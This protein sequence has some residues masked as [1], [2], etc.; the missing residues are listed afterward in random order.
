MFLGLRERQIAARVDQFGQQ[1]VREL[2]D[3]FDVTEVTIRRDLRKLEQA[4]LLKRTHGGA[5]SLTNG[6][7]I[8]WPVLLARVNEAPDDTSSDALILPPIP[9]RVAYTLREGA[10]RNR[11]PI[12]AESVPQDDA[13]YVGHDNLAAGYDL[14][15]WAGGALARRLGAKAPV[16]AL[17]I[18]HHALPNTRERSQGFADGLNASISG[19]H[20]VVRTVDGHGMYDEAYRA[21]SDALRLHPETNLVFGI[22]DDS[23][24]AAIQALQDL[25]REPGDIVVVSIGAEG[26]TALDVLNRDSFLQAVIALFPEVVGRLTIDTIVR[27]W[28]GE[29]VS[30]AVVMPHRLITP[31]SIGEFYARVGRDWDLKSDCADE[32][33]APYGHAPA[34]APPD[35]TISFAILYRTHEWYQNVNQAMRHRCSELGISLRNADWKDDFHDEIRELQRLIGKLAASYIDDGDSVMLDSGVTTEYMCS[36]LAVPQNLSVVTNSLSIFNRLRGLTSIELT[37]TG[38]RYNKSIDSLVGRGAQ[39]TLGD[40]RVNK[41]FIVARGLSLEFGVSAVREAEAEIHR[42]MCHA[43]RELVVLAD[44]TLLDTDAKF[45]SFHLDEVDTIITDAGITPSQRHELTQRGIKVLVAGD[46]LNSP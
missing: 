9:E 14:G 22:N 26:N 15:L 3:F 23:A 16:F 19:R 40:L 12:I 45:H 28:Q 5:I 6:G 29:D 38:G 11:I 46:V 30:N 37:L 2:A 13:C 33:L 25:G 32:L 4:H 39:L 42:S 41:A 27:L 34:A 20:V 43:A 36:F 8:G 7:T 24:L 17:D 21:A 10:L 44:H 18:S 35:R 31:G 1:T